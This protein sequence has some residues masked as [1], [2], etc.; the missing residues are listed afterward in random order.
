MSRQNVELLRQA[1]D[2]V[3]RRDLPGFLARMDVDVEADSQLAPIEGGYHGHDGI[4]RWWRN[5]FEAFPDYSIEPLEMRDLGELTLTAI[6]THAHG[7]GSDI[8]VDQT[9]WH[10]ARWRNERMVWWG[11]F[12]TEREALKAAGLRE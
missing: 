9:L 10:V 8:A 6:R 5:V 3:N 11:A 1:L 4:R 12:V 2:A 7:A